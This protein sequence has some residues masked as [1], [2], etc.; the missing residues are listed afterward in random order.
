M[1]PGEICRCHRDVSLPCKTL[2][3]L[4][5]KANRASAGRL[6]AN[7]RARA[8]LLPRSGVLHVP[9]FCSRRL[10]DSAD[11]RAIT[12]ARCQPIARRVCRCSTILFFSCR[13]PVLPAEQRKEGAEM[14]AVGMLV[15]FDVTEDRDDPL[16]H[17]SYQMGTRRSPYSGIAMVEQPG[18]RRPAGINRIQFS[19]DC[20]GEAHNLGL[21]VRVQQFIMKSAGSLR[22]FE[23]PDEGCNAFVVGG[24]ILPL[25][26]CRE[27]RQSFG[28]KPIKLLT[29]AIPRSGAWPCMRWSCDANVVRFPL[30]HS[31]SFVPNSAIA[32]SMSMAVPSARHQNG[33][34]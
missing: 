27:S 16:G 4:R 30:N 12:L 10:M 22:Q 15:C 1:V 18:E 3:R 20:A 33:L 7:S 31:S 19:H 21:A 17:R 23:S 26:Q 28:L 6:S 24:Y 9:G 2:A 5:R 34:F 25:E 29:I 13:V 11:A 14:G 8:A 32:A